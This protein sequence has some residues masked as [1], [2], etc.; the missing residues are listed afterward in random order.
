MTVAISRRDRL[1]EETV[2]EIKAVARRQLVEEGPGAIALRGIA[3]EMGMTAPGLYRYYSSLEEL[4]ASL[5]VDLYDDLVAGMESARDVVPLDDVMGRLLAVSRAFRTW[6]VG[7]PPEFGLIFGQP[8]T[9]LS[10][11]P[12]GPAAK[13]AARFGGIF[14][15]I[16]GQLWSSGLLRVPAEDE[17]DP[18][19]RRQ[20]AAYAKR[21]GGPLPPE[22][23]YVFAACWVRVYG[24]VAMEVFGK[25]RWVFEESAA[26]FETELRQLARFLGVSESYRP[27]TS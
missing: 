23:Y 4:I 3:R 9:A 8:I 21:I 27:P 7:H 20:L 25:L 1:R 6:S 13:A 17:L 5:T 22:A 10:M 2:R 15:E 14:R 26:L 24:V 16:F 19:M 18:L 12:E 11:P